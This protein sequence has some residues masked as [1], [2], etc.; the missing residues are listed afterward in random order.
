M[1]MRDVERHRPF[2]VTENGTRQ[3]LVPVRAEIDYPVVIKISEGFD[4]L[5]PRK[6]F[7]FRM[8]RSQKCPQGEPPGR[9]VRI[10]V[11]CERN[12]DMRLI[13][14]VPLAGQQM[15]RGAARL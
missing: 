15:H 6:L 10:E 4:S 8:A 12:Q 11:V 7:V 3:P 13:R 9:A 2:A 1:G 5:T 14:Q